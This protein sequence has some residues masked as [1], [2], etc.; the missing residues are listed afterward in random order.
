MSSN[1]RMTR[2]KGPAEELSLPP[3]RMR[4]DVSTANE[5]EKDIQGQVQAN[6]QNQPTTADMPSPFARPGSWAGTCTTPASEGGMPPIASNPFARP[7]SR[8]GFAPPEPTSP[9][10][11]VS[12][13]SDN[14]LQEDVNTSVSWDLVD[15]DTDA[16]VANINLSF[17]HKA[18]TDPKTT[19]SINTRQNKAVALNNEINTLYNQDFFV[20]DT[21][22]RR[23]SQV[24]DKSNYS[25]LLPN[26]NAALQLRLPDLLIYLKTDTYLVDVKTGHHYAI[27][28]N[29]IEKM[30]VL[31]KLYSAWPY[32][33]LLQAIHDDAVRFG[34]NSPEPATSKQ[35][36]PVAQPS[37]SIDR[38]V[39][40]ANKQHPSP[41]MPTIVNYE[42]PSFNLQIPKRMLTRSERDQVLRNHMTATNTTFNKVAV[43]ED[44]MW[45]EPHNAAHY[46]EVQRVQKNQHIQVAIKLQHMLEADNEFRQT[47]GL[48][49]LD[50]PEHL[51]T[52]RNMD[53]AP[54]REQH[55]MAISSEVE[56]LRQQLKVKG[57][58]PAPPNYMQ[59]NQQN[60]HFQ[61]IQPAKLS[62]LQPQDRLFFDPL[63]ST[64]TGSTG[65]QSDSTHNPTQDCSS[66]PPKVHTPS[67]RVPEP[68]IP[69]TPYVNQAAV[70]QH[71]RMQSPSVPPT[72][73]TTVAPPPRESPKASVAQETLITLATAQTTPPQAQ[74]QLTTSPQRPRTSKSKDGRGIKQ[75]KNVNATDT[76][77]VCW[78]CGEPGHKK[79]DCRKPPFCGKCRKEGHVPALCH[80]ST[81]PTLP[82]LL[83][84]QVDKF[85]NSTNQ[86][87]HCGRDHV[88]GSCPVRYQP[89]ATSSTSHYGSPK[90]RAA[91]NT[92]AS[93][94]VRSQV[95]P[96][97][98]PLAQVNSLAQPTRSNSFPPPPYFPIPFPPPPIPP[99]N[100]SI[101]PSAPASDLSAAISLMT[102]AVN[103]GNANTTNITDALQR[104]TTQFADALQKTIQRG[105]DAQAEENRNA[106]LDK[107]FDKIKIFDGSNPAECHPWLEEVHA[108]CSQTGR[109]F[110]EMLLLCAG[111]AVRDF[112][113]DMAPDATDEQI[114]NNLITGYSDLQGLGCKQAAYDNIAQRPEEPVRS[115]IVRYSRL[116]KLLNGTAPNEVRMRTTSM[117]FVNS[118]RGY[119]SSKVENR[120]LGMNDRN[121]SLGDTFAVAL[122][123]KL[124]A[125]AS[126]RRH[127]KRN[128]ITINN[129]HTEDQDYH[130]L[131]DTQEVHVRNP[132]YKG[133]NYDPNYQARKA[134]GKQ[135]LQ[136]E[137][138]NN[139]YKATAARPAANHNNDLAR[140]SDIAGEV[141]LKTTV[142]GYQLLKMNELIKNAAAWRARMPKANRFDKYFDKEATKTTPKVQIN[143]ATLQVMGQT[144]KDCGYTKEEFIEAV[145]MYEHFGNI[146]LEDVQTPSPQ[147]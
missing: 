84:Q 112:I 45:Q 105:V 104:T 68:T 97:V 26:R 124:K 66:A 22:G 55:F 128:T 116:F 3:T 125:I 146:E 35:P 130:Q 93:G 27:Y 92:V 87:I 89:K 119:L 8:A 7:D 1:S 96:Q 115:Y 79:R 46:K 25:S 94:Q 51:W 83:Q 80:L 75:S 70:E 145:E 15:T 38:D 29:R 56:V 52:V 111:Q 41:C 139:Q 69:P 78:R 109:P 23:L 30:S 48:P 127:N 24:T 36:A 62:P 20:A 138:T 99:S 120:L 67:P 57:M 102:N 60:V 134:E 49:Q 126:E 53:T 132:N 54:V 98:S 44:L 118:L 17:T 12:S 16:E 47:A 117:H 129:V 74:N 11:S 108:L 39:Q 142:D 2:S 133:K 9:Q 110:K 131:E 65:S 144:A 19:D 86:C 107:Q 14:Q 71:M 106:R 114:K 147:D 50:L 58:Y 72:N 73:I 88:P 143:S 140:S 100:A 21:T 136:L 28:H 33:Q 90:Q 81:G 91:N 18:V 137:T 113:L 34:I 13:R 37:S 85:S 82:S 76:A 123:C 121:Y 31:P 63:L 42:P 103:K 4:K 40:T 10:S 32:R 135:Q 59:I 122:Q 101:A 77:Q 141:T 6:E 95:T 61:P 43:L 64:T 5:G